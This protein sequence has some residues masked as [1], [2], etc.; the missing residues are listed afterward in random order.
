LFQKTRPACRA[1]NEYAALVALNTY[2]YMIRK[3]H[4]TARLVQQRIQNIVSSGWLGSSVRI[5]EMSRE[6]ALCLHGHYEPE[7]FP[8][9]RLA[10]RNPNLKALVFTQGLT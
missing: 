9:F 8:G 3:L 10:I 7:I 1:R 6:F 2:F 5:D 4:P